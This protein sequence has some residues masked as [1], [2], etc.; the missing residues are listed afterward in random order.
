MDMFKYTEASWTFEASEDGYDGWYASAGRW[1]NQH[2]AMKA[3]Q[4]FQ[5][6]VYSLDRQC[7]AVRIVQ[8]RELALID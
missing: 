2:E 8:V 7:R 4:D 5:A 6:Y 1:D 3:A